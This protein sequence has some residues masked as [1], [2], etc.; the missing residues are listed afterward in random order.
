[1]KNS[2]LIF[3]SICLIAY[4]LGCFIETSFNIAEW[5]KFLRSIIGSCGVLFGFMGTGIILEVQNNK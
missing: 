2:I 4:L 3:I 5:D 1:M